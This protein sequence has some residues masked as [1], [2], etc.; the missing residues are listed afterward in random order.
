MKPD[1]D[2]KIVL[3]NSSASITANGSVGWESLIIGKPVILFGKPWYASCYGAIDIYNLIKNNSELSE[4][5]NDRNRIKSYT[6]NFYSYV[7]DNCYS[8]VPYDRI[9]KFYN[10][11]NDESI[12]WEIL[13]L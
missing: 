11:K 2:T 13:K 1:L 12:F 9:S 8:F 10:E 6:K 5:L 4:L 3:E 7:S